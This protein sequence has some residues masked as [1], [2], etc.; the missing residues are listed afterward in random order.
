MG[1]EISK[2]FKSLAG[3]VFD[4]YTSLNILSDYGLGEDVV[5]KGFE[6]KNGVLG[7]NRD[8]Y[9]NIVRFL[10]SSILRKV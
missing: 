8:V 5:F 6:V 9:L 4:K 1:L 2:S 7:L 3:A 10:D